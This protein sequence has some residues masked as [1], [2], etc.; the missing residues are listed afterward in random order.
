M[1]EN[2]LSSRERNSKERNSAGYATGWLYQPKRVR[3]NEWQRIEVGTVMRAR[4]KWVDG[5]NYRARGR[6]RKG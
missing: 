1:N 4:G 6:N 2:H 5:R 3:E